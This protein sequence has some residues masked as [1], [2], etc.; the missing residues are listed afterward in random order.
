MIPADGETGGAGSGLRQLSAVLLAAAAARAVYLASFAGTPLYDYFRNDHLYYREWALRIAAGR[1]LSVEP[2]EQ[3]PLY[4]Y[5]LG[6]AYR[7]FGPREAPALFLQLLGGVGT[8]ALIWWCARR[9]RGS[10][11]ALAAGLLAALYGPF[12]FAEALVMKTF[13]EPL[14]VAAALAAGL[15]GLGSG[16]ARWH[17]AAGAAVGLACLVREVHVL[18]L[19]PLL[20][21]SLF[22][23][24]PAARTPAGRVRAAG[25]LLL[26]CLLALA[27]SFAHN[28]VVAREPVVVSSAG[29]QN[30]YIAFGPSA[31]GYYALPPFAT[32][33]AHREHE[34]FREEAFVRTGRRM[35]RGESSRYWLGETLRWVRAEPWRA[36][37][38]AWRKAAILFNDAELPDS[39]D[40]AVTRGYV[41]LLRALPSFGWISGLGLLGFLLLWRRPGGS[42][43]AAGFA[44][45]LVLEVLLT[46]NLGRYRLALAAVWLVCA[47]VGAAWLASRETWRSGTR[48]LGVAGAA[49]AAAFSVVSFAD[50]PGRDPAALAAVHDLFRRQ[51]EAAVPLRRRLPELAA[52]L[53]DRPRDPDLLFEQAVSLEGI[54]RLSEAVRAYEAALAAAPDSVAAHVRLIPIYSRSGETL[55]ALEHARALAT[56]RPGEAG[57]WVALGGVLV[58]K[59]ES[60]TQGGAAQGAFE[61]AAGALARARELDPRH[62]QARYLLGR[63]EL[64][65]GREEQ[66]LGELEAAVRLASSQV[67]PREYLMA[68]GLA[69]LA[70]ERLAG[71]AGAAAHPGAP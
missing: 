66:A 52:T 33:V 22:P 15:R 16:R 43:L 46:F 42:R 64:F 61:Q 4:A 58:R 39:E 50:P 1:W 8:V 67:L 7:V 25:P 63:V 32:S 47:G 35:S 48:R 59:G 29:G 45:V 40:F 13:L 26:G 2:F 5:L 54:G 28:W 17:A 36:V 21:A 55:R 62:F 6:A 60:A 53:A 56:A 41:P 9:L 12:M 18:L 69:R 31:T 30:L 37:R 44:A 3:G 51:A 68:R 65:L 70:R 19:V 20:L 57:S 34:D 38:L 27:P 49:T 24:P 23:P 10:A 14:L 11:A 71:R